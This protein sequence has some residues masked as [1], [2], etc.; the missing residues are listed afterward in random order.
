MQIF[1]AA[2]SIIYYC[3]Y[4]R[5]IIVALHYILVRYILYIAAFQIFGAALH[6]IIR[7]IPD[8]LL[9]I[10]DLYCW[11]Y[12]VLHSRLILLHSQLFIFAFL[13][14]IVTFSIYL[15]ICYISYIAIAAFQKF[16]AALHIIIHC[17]PDYSIM[18]P[19]FYCGILHYL[20][21]PIF[22]II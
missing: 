2:F 17:I 13:I 22:L 8:Y 6:I 12:S 9:L 14:F 15:F 10:S 4:Y 7:C 21:L 18:I 5:L 16:G 11:I 20:L 1:I 3:H 19:D